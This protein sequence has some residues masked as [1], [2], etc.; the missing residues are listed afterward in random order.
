[1]L[2]ASLPCQY[3]SQRCLVGPL[4]TA[5]SRLL[6]VEEEPCRYVMVFV[7]LQPCPH[8]SHKLYI[9]C[10]ALSSSMI[11]GKAQTSWSTPTS[12]L[13][14]AALKL[15]GQGQ[16]IKMLEHKLASVRCSCRPFVRSCLFQAS[17]RQRLTNLVQQAGSDSHMSAM[18][19][20]HAAVEVAAQAAISRQWDRCEALPAA[21][22]CLHC[23]ACVSWSD[24]LH[25]SACLK[26]AA[27]TFSSLLCWTF[28][29]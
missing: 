4:V 13:S 7:L 5:A 23:C 17:E 3:L 24:C 26:W 19:E 18:L 15:I 29:G 21:S 14:A 27:P 25:G 2:S 1:M 8:L 20:S 10:G 16:S 12:C 22:A 9:K 28:M 11:K 6:M